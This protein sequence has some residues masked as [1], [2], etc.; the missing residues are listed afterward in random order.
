MNNEI[1]SGSDTE[2]TATAYVRRELAAAR[3]AARRSK[4]GGMI[5]AVVICGYFSVLTFYLN[6]F[7]E[8]KA[9]AQVATG[10]ALV[11]INANATQFSAGLEKEA[12]RFLKALPDRLIEAIPELRR[13]M[14]VELGTFARTECRRHASELGDQLDAFLAQN[15]DLITEF[16]SASNEPEVIRA[17]ADDLGQEFLQTLEVS[18]GGA[19]ESLSDKL[20]LTL[21]GLQRAE[22]QLGHLAK[23]TNLTEY[24]ADQR[25]AIAIVA[26]AA[27]EGL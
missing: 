16:V 17:L 27:E 25:K 10:Q 18:P 19:D 4:Q 21:A 14:E 12:R 13:K 1:K 23:G 7:L 20:K 2:A 5:L 26:W 11:A 3:V 8:P 24:E 9:V 15:S 6:T 22:E